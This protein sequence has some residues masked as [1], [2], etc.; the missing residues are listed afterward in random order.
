MSTIA[1][2]ISKLIAKADSTSHPEEADLFMAK[3]QELMMAHGLSLLDI[4]KLDSDDPVG[5]TDEAGTYY[6]SEG[7]AKHLGTQLARYYGC[8]VMFSQVARNKFAFGIA[9]RESARVTFAL[10]FPFVVR[11][12]RAQAREAVK[13]GEASTESRAKT[14]IGNALTFRIQRLRLAENNNEKATATRNALVPVDLNRAALEERWPNLRTGRTAR[15][16]TTEAAKNRASKI[17]LHRQTGAAP[18]SCMIA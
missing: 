15:L 6:A 16:N 10:M 1:E 11:Q 13:C 2:K 17:S 12:V 9:G 14:A 3:A 4:G 8:E 18:A 7:W 5:T